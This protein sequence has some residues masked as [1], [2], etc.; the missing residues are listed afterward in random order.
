[1]V[2]KE[3]LEEPQSEEGGLEDVDEELFDGLESTKDE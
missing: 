1:M 3:V 2:S